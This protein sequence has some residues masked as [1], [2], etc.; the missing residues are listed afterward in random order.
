[1]TTSTESNPLL[2]FSGLTRFDQ[3]KPEHVAPAISSLLKDCMTVIEKLATSSS[4]VTWQNFILPL[5]QVTEKLGRAWSVVGHLNAVADTPAL[6]NAYNENQP[7]VV[8]FWTALAQDQRVFEKYQALRASDHYTQL[9]PS[10]KK[11]IENALRDFR[12]GG[13]ELTPEKKQRFAE[14]QERQAALATR[15]S[16]NVLDATNDFELFV[17]Q[18]TDLA[19]LPDDA[20]QA[21]RVAAQANQREGFKFTLHFPSYFPVLQYADNRA[22]RE[23][24]YRANATKASE[25]GTDF[26]QLEQWDNTQNIITILKLRHEEAVLLGYADFAQLSLEPKMATTPQQVIDFL[27]DLGH[28]ARPFAEKDAEELRA[29]A[30]QELSLEPL[31]AWDMAY[32]AEK[33]RQQRYAFSEQEVKQYFP[34]SK[35]VAGLFRVAEKLFS[36]HIKPDHASTWHKDVKFFRIERETTSGVELVAQ[37]Y[38]DLYARPGKRGGAWMDDARGHQRTERG[39]QTPIAY[40][41]CNFSE[42]VTHNGKTQPA[43]FTHDEAITLFHEFGHGLHHMLT[44]V[45][46]LA[47]SGIS[48]VEWDAV[49]LP[50]Q[51]M[52]NFCWEWDVL[53][54]MTAH[55]DTGEPLPR[56]LFDKMI[57]A[58]NFH[59]GLQTLRQVEF[60]LFDMHLHH[61]YDTDANKSVQDVLNAV[62]DQVAVIRPPKFNRF[63][64]SFSHIFAGGYAAG[65]YSYKWAE[66]LSADAY[67][68]F[69]DARDAG[70]NIV[71]LEM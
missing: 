13:A 46:E 49:E 41:T 47:V 40:L 55:I 33:L 50:S 37:F 70:G 58:K 44:K 4:E 12:L 10:R 30:H 34:E 53:Q 9:S 1:M 8:E 7:K 52:E 61:D 3:I 71:S 68:A 17:E 38:M 2:D 63:Q 5:E 21:A 66:V 19:G 42:P 28:R 64:N 6:R 29:F 56:T 51:F 32:A 16:E 24:I 18:E 39:I 35:V 54:H 59:A 22:L 25:L 26:S 14:I 20:K 65:Y 27:T 31:E 60:S 57:A 62:R 45:D 43:L 23:R 15:F 36:V 67:S 11:T 69:E 48:G